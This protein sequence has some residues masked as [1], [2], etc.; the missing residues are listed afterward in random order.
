VDVEA[1]KAIPEFR[2]LAYARFNAPPFD[3]ELFAQEVLAHLAHMR[4]SN[5]S[6]TYLK[7]EE[8][9][10]LPFLAAKEK[11]DE[12]NRVDPKTMTTIR[13]PNG[14][15]TW[16]ALNFTTSDTKNG[17]GL[18]LSSR[19]EMLNETWRWNEA[20][21]VPQLRAYLENQLGLLQPLIARV[22]YLK[23]G[24][25][26]PF[27][28]DAGRVEYTK[29]GYRQINLTLCS[30]GAP[31]IIKIKDR[32]V[33]ADSPAFTFKD[34][35]HHGVPIVTSRRLALVVVGLFDRNRWNDLLDP[36]SAVLDNG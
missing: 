35:Y 8:Y 26:V 1:I 4:E 27:H 7:P 28:K 22:L 17:N 34:L 6:M 13:V 32:I 9:L 20:L 10:S 16:H 31:L 2:R 33:V 3:G 14:K 21:P 24:G 11:Y 19:A 18:G 15:P 5:L 30:G 25:F 36:T 12:L 23:P 29:K